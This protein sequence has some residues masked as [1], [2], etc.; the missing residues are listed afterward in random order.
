MGRGAGNASTEQLLRAVSAACSSAAEDLLQ[1]LV[2]RHFNPLKA[3]HGWGDNLFYQVGADHGLH[4]TYVQEV[5]GDRS[6]SDVQ[7]LRWIRQIP[8]DTAKFD[9]G[10]LEQARGRALVARMPVS[11]KLEQIA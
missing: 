5:L 8:A 9:R 6:L 2:A 4:P 1:L 3:K 10:I 11:A 7:A